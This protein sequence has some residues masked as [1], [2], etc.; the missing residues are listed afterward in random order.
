MVAD[1]SNHQENT[2][3]LPPPENGSRRAVVRDAELIV[4]VGVAGAMPGVAE[5]GENAQLAPE[6]SPAV[7]DNVTV[8]LK[9]FFPVTTIW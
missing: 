4:S 8:P 7:Q 5:E 3:G 1:T 2:G 6:G 9:L